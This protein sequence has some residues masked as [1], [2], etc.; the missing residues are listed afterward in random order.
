M[1]LAW[2]WGPTALPSMLAPWSQPCSFQATERSPGHLTQSLSWGNAGVT[3]MRPS[4]TRGAVQ[5]AGRISKLRFFL[6]DH[7]VQLPQ[8]CPQLGTPPSCLCMPH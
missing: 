8:P 5:D 1:L 2:E 7:E 3:R 6:V 4:S